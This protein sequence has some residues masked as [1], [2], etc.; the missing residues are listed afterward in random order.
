ML[1]SYIH[2]FRIQKLSGGC[3]EQQINF[4][5]SPLFRDIFL[6]IIPD[7]DAQ[8]DFVAFQKLAD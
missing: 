3:F 4:Q 2:N 7:I 8:V 1:H 6:G 5:I